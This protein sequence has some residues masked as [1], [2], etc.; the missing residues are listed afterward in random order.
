MSIDTENLSHNLVIFLAH[1]GIAY[2]IVHHHHADSSVN[3]AQAAHIPLEKMIK[4]VV[5]ADDDGYVMALVSADHHVNIAALNHLLHRKLNLASDDDIARLFSDCE[6]GAIPPIG[7]AY[8]IDVVVDQG[9]DQ[10][11]DVYIE[12][13]NHDD[14]LHLKGDSF[15][16]LMKHAQHA[17]IGKH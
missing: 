2:D 10:Q 1:H 16:K 15:R 4:S 9:L 8:G 3:V 6:D 12:A 17:H 5:L 14:L 7:E 13:G 11:H